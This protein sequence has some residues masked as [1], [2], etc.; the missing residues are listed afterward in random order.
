M[1]ELLGEDSRHRPWRGYVAAYGSV[2][3]PFRQ[4]TLSP[5][6]WQ[7]AAHPLAQ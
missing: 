7:L 3:A 2:T 6:V 5:S 4:D 1:T